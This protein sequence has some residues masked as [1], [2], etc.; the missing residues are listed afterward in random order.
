MGVPPNVDLG[1]EATVIISF[2]T[3]QPLEGADLRVLYLPVRASCQLASADTPQ[4][5]MD[6]PSFMLATLSMT[7]AEN[8]LWRND[9]PYAKWLVGYLG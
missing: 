6:P 4:V 5:L 8:Q 2:A 1:L 3:T 9:I 7:D